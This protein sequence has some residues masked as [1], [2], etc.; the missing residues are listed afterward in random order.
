MP[1]VA[2]YLPIRHSDRPTADSWMV[3]TRG[4]GRTVVA[5]VVAVVCG[6]CTGHSDWHT[7]PTVAARFTPDRTTVQVAYANYVSDS[8]SEK[9]VSLHKGGST[10]SAALEIRRD[11]DMC[12][13]EGCISAPAA[14]WVPCL[15]V[16]LRL[17]QPAPDNVK[18]VAAP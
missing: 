13:A 8:C 10:W 17:D 16:S 11:A 15:T 1:G 6:A 3:S 18:V 9:R 5:I 2:P 12:T 7:V 14:P 4:R